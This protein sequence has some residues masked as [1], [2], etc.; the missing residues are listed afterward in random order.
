[1]PKSKKGQ[2]PDYEIPTFKN[3]K[4]AVKPSEIHGMGLF[5]TKSL[6]KGEV[7]GLYQGE[8]VDYEGDHVLWIFDEVTEREYGIDGV[9][10]TRFVNHCRKP[11]A[12]FNG[13]VLEAIS[14]IGA[15]DEITHDYGEAWSD[16]G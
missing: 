4:A 12:Y 5:A 16:L 7:I 8:E 6:R 9:N 11:N 2:L 10:E 14:P 15:G 3:P 1:M 13:E